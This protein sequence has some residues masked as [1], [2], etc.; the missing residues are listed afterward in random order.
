[1]DYL[2][3]KEYTVDCFSH[4]THGLMFCSGRERVRVKWYINE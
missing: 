1:M 2:P 3:G 4:R